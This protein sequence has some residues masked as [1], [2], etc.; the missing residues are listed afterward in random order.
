MSRNFSDLLRNHESE[1]K[2]LCV[3]IG[4]VLDSDSFTYPLIRDVVDALSDKVCAFKINPA[5]FFARD[6]LGFRSLLLIA[7]YITSST[8]VPLILD[9]KGGD[10]AYTNTH[11]VRFAFDVVGADAVVVHPWGGF[12]PLDC[13]FEDSSKGVFLWS[14]SSAPG[15]GP[16]TFFTISRWILDFV[17]R[18]VTRTAF[19]RWGANPG[20]GVVAGANDISALTHVR[21]IVGN[22]VPIM[23]P[24]VGVQGGRA[25]N[26]IPAA[27]GK[28]G[29]GRVI[30]VC[31]R[32]VIGAFSGPDP[33]AA[34]RQRIEEVYEHVAAASTGSQ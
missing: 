34:V 31:G 12:D 30:P 24:G 4:S 20:F 26:F 21:R 1:G 3:E 8:D 2:V 23:V 25:A 18:K 14:R 9:I 28:S 17:Y 5:P 6:T 11:W 33:V 13:F 10:V 22:D 32:T 15:D 27:L 7:S 29:K 16:Q 19:K